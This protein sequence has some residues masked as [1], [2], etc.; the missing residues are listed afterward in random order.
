MSKDKTGFEKMSGKMFSGG[1]KVGQPVAP[2]ARMSEEERRARV[3]AAVVGGKVESVQQME[4]PV[5]EAPAAGEAGK[6]A[7]RPKGEPR[8]LKPLNFKV[9][10]DFH[11]KVKMLSADTGRTVVDLLYEAFE[12]LF[13]K[14]GKGD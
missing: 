13:A 1:V 8:E 3:A 5:P 9:V 6:G 12:D 11:R 4:D 14:M 2:V 7:G 10:P